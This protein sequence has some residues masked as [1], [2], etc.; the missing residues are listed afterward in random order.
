MRYKLLRV[1][2]HEFISNMGKK[3]MGGILMHKKKHIIIFP[4]INVYR[5]QKKIF[6]CLILGSQE[7]KYYDSLEQR[8]ETELSNTIPKHTNN[9]KFSHNIP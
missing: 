8:P 3:I 1:I 4:A 5:N 9:I 6:I 2:Y 7:I